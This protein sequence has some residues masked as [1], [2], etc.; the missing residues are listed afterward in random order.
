ME[1]TKTER[2]RVFRLLVLLSQHTPIRRLFRAAENTCIRY[3]DYMYSSQ[4]PYILQMFAG[5]LLDGIEYM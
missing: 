1:I 5:Y 2:L 4:K 3:I